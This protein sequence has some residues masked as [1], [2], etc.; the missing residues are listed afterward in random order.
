MLASSSINAFVRVTDPQRAR[1]FYE[2]VLGLQV[3]SDNPF[4][5]VFRA[6]NALVMAQKAE[7]FSPL[8][9]TVLGWEVKNINKVIV[10]LVKNGVVFERYDG[11]DQDELG[12]WKSPDGNVAWFKDPDGNILSL[13]EHANY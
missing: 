9:G 5:I 12:V 3:V 13:S 1:H 6:N 10:A 7:K 2:K 11:M 8:R 4:M